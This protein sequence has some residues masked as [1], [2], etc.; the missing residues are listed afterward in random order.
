MSF[1]RTY[2]RQQNS[3]TFFPRRFGTYFSLILIFLFGFGCGYS[4]L[5]IEPPSLSS[6]S[7]DASQI[8]VCFSPGE[9]CETQI[10]AALRSAQSE[11]LIQAYALTSKPIAS[12]LMDAQE[13]GVSIKILYDAKQASQKHSQIS[14]LTQHGIETKVDAV[15]GLAHNK[16]MIIDEKVLLTGSYNFS[17]AAN[18]R[19]S[20]NLL[21]IN[22]ASLAK[23]YKD[24]W[25]KRF[26]SY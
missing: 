8:T 18:Y 25:L 21:I 16:V 12:A 20:E 5:T 14:F 6:I 11:I 3:L 15:S 10:I 7:R 23:L 22:D 24:N 13:R 19:N 9:Q 4:F 2:K 17:H 1:K 26:N